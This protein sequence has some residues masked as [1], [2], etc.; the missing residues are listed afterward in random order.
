[1]KNKNKTERL[2]ALATKEEKKAIERKAKEHN[3]SVGRLLV[4]AA[5]FISAEYIQK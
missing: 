3:I 2:V 1:M 5:L 4:N